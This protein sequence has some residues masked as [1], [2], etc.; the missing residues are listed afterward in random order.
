MSSVE[1]PIDW[2]TELFDQEV[3]ALGLSCPLPLLKAK[4]ALSQMSAGQTLRVVATDAGSWRDMHAFAE[5][6]GHAMQRA[7]RNDA[8]FCYWLRKA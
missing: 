2:Q 5:R 6:A 3:D 8:L 1:L 7:E 4:L